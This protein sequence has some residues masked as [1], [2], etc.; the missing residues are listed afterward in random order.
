MMSQFILK[1]LVLCLVLFL[2]GVSGAS[3]QDVIT[4]LSKKNIP[5]EWNFT[6]TQIILFG[7]V[8][9][10]EAA[11]SGSQAVTTENSG[12]SKP[13]VIIVVRGPNKNI[14]ARQKKR[15]AGI[16]INTDPRKFNN[17]PGYYSVVS[18]RP[19]QEITT[20]SELENLGIG[21]DALALRLAKVGGTF[22]NNKPGAHSQAIIRIMKQDGL[23]SEIPDGVNLIG[24][25]LFRANIAL[26]A[27]IPVGTFDAIVYLYK[28]GKLLSITSQSI[29]IQKQGVEALVYSLAFDYPF[30]YGVLAV[31]L[32]VFSGLV[33]SAI[34]KKD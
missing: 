2:L 23:Y 25:K 32:A 15:I 6:G 13:D 19:I 7:V 16:W 4:D 14:M 5:I 33:A 26:P 18:T 1:R 17:V 8:D 27:N 12:Q 30:F 21:F 31:M 10:V 3:A 29:Y 11:P 20:V 22:V 24:G 9:G 28:E 34:F